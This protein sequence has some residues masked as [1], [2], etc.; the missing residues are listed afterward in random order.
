MA[1]DDP[2]LGCL[3]LLARFHQ[4]PASTDALK[5]GF[6]NDGSRL[7]PLAFL[8]L[9][10][11]IGFSARITERPLDTFHPLLLPAVL[12]LHEG[13]CLLIALGD[14]DENEADSVEVMFSESGGGRK[15]SREKLQRLYSGRAIFVQP[16][17][18]LDQRAE[19]MAPLPRRSWFWGTLLRYRRQYA[20]VAL[21]SLFINLFAVASSLFAMNV[22]DRVVP[23]RALET[24]WVLA[25]GVSLALFFDF[26]LRLLRSALLD[27]AGKKADVLI[28]ARLFR[29]VLA[30]KLEKRAA[31]AGSMANTLKE[32]ESLRDFF[33]SATLATLIDLPFVFLFVAIIAYIGAWLALVPI[34]AV[35]LVVGVGLALQWPLARAVREHQAE[36]AQKHGLLVEAIS[37][38][39]TLKALG[40]EGAVQAKWEQL[41]GLTASSS[42]KS[43]MISTLAVN[44]TLFVQQMVSVFIVVIGVYMIADGVLSMG[45]LIACNILAGR[46]LAPLGQLSGLLMRYQG[47]RIAYRGLDKLMH[48]DIDRA[49]GQSYLH[50]SLW[51]GALAF[52]NVTFA[53]PGSRQPALQGIGITVRA[54]E[55][56]AILGRAG[57]GK[58][59]LAKLL[60]GLYAPVS[61]SIR[62]DGV[63]IGQIDPAD[64]RRVIGYAGQDARLFYGSLREN[65]TL[66]AAGTDDDAILKAAQVVG[67]D[68]WIRRQPNGLDRRIG[69]NGE[70]LS[71][72]Q[73]QAVALTRV[74]LRSPR[75]LLLDEPTAAFDHNAEQYFVAAMPAYLAERT[76]LL[77]THKPTLLALV[78][79]IVVLDE[80]RVIAD[81]PRDKI[82]QAL[83]QR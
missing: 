38:L 79:R 16:V 71:G 9:A 78:E 39:E 30:I 32:F 63:N 67:I 17:C 8:R 7:T 81:G 62:I 15:L 44:F 22:Y 24:L 4:R 36:S 42:Q 26:L 34:L 76:L 73:R 50:R 3:A 23:N 52:D 55:R 47:A 53:Y 77:V 59:T 14:G 61:G 45:A 2:L 35:P 70:G 10:E 51:Q 83:A 66:G 54:G 68:E 69:E 75:I 64:L 48:E 28:S 18:R 13:A 41:L 60:D 56:V 58:S 43:R 49:E 21:A 29:Q 72:G 37:G 1:N 25:I 19:V 33:T 5:A 40:A 11:S 12:L 6:P 27:V 80:G 65:I 74:I 20:D 31:S 46:A 82:L 57:S